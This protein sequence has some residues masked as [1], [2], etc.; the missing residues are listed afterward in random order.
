MRIFAE[1]SSERFTILSDGE[2]IGTLEASRGCTGGYRGRYRVEIGVEGGQISV[3]V[4]P[5]RRG[6]WR[7][8]KIRSAFGSWGIRRLWG[9]Y[10]PEVNRRRRLILLGGF[11]PIFEEHSPASLE[12]ILALYDPSRG[13][14]QLVPI[15]TSRG[16]RVTAT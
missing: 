5:G 12:P 4:E 2:R 15:L 3:E 11:R 1:F 8:V 7:R 10:L 14:E 16:L 13:G 9:C 6:R